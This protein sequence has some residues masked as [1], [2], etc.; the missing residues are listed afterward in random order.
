MHIIG[1]DGGS[2]T[3]TLLVFKTTRPGINLIPAFT[4]LA[5]WIAGR[6]V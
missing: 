1:A 5:N 2:D 6:H 3:V 4:A